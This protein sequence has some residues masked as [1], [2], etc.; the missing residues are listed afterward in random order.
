MTRTPGRGA[1]IEAAPSYRK[2]RAA[3]S[4]AGAMKF[5]SAKIR[6][7]APGGLTLRPMRAAI[8]VLMWAI[9]AGAAAQD[10]SSWRVPQAPA[11]RADFAV[12]GPDR[13]RLVL[14]SEGAAQRVVVEHR[15][16][17]PRG[18]RVLGAGACETPCALYVARAPLTLRAEAWRLRETTLE[19]DAPERASVLRL[20]AASR[21]QWNLGIGLTGAGLTVFLA[22]A[23][24][25]L[26]AQTTGAEGLPTGAAVGGGVAA[27]ALLAAGIPLLALNRT[28]VV[29]LTPE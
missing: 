10:A 9:P 23:G 14:R 13:V 28:G 5:G 25:A 1:I 11:G 6:R 7:R 27:G 8:A 2:A 24:Y 18:P 26:A 29:S 19:L 17:T 21:R 20:R 4:D 3:N 16:A 12:G 15:V 22:L